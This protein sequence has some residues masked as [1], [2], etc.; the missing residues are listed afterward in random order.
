MN[1]PWKDFKRFLGMLRLYARVGLS[2][3]T[4]RK[5]YVMS[6]YWVL[7]QIFR[8]KIPWLIELSVTYRCN[9]RCKHCSVSNYFSDA[10]LSRELKTGEIKKVLDEAV[11]MGIPKVDYFG[12]EPLLRADIVELVRYGESLG[13]YI[14]LTTNAWLLTR[15]MVKALKGA[16]ISCINVSLDS[17]EEEEHDRLR[18][19]SGVY[20]RAVEAVKGCQEEG[21]PCIV[22][23]YATRRRI[24]N[25]ATPGDDSTLTALIQFSK[26]IRATAIRILFPIIAGEWVKKKEIEL[27]EAEKKLVIE[28][29]DPSFAFIEGAY[30]VKGKTKVC[31]A[32]RGRMLNISPYGD[33]QLCVT[34]PH[35][36]GNVK[37]KGLKY[38]ISSMWSHPI[39]RKNKGTSCCSTEDLKV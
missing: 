23:T 1:S 37:D 3:M 30:S 7:T 13:L 28:N 24:Q 22:S 31:Q 16:G 4:P 18:G 5:A 29:M 10:D 32:L 35:S 17:V 33:I 11:A 14:S 27:S 6:R 20:R 8:R 26:S 19:L 25:F 38:L 12:G 36:F 15:P 39:Y 21:I 34:F 2:R 9:C